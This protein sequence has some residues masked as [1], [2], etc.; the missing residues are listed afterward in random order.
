MSQPVEKLHRLCQVLHQVAAL[1]V[2]ARAKAQ[3]QDQDTMMSMIG[4]DFDMYLSQLGLVPRQNFSTD[5]VGMEEEEGGGESAQLAGWFS[6][7]SHVMGLMEE[8]DFSEF[9]H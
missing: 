1:Y 9:L 2:E 8:D 3:D 6:G 7:N 4:N 5:F